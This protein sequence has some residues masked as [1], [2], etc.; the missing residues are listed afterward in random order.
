[1]SKDVFLSNFNCI[2]KCTL[3]S[4]LRDFQFRLLHNAVITNTRLRQWGIVEDENCT[5]CRRSPESILHLLIECHYSTQLGNSLFDYIEEIAGI[6]IKPT[7]AEFFLGILDGDL[8]HF[9][10]NI[11]IIGKQYIYASR[12]LNKKPCFQVLIQKI[13]LEMKLQYLIA[14]QNEK[15]DL[16]K[17][18]WSL[19]DQITFM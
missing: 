5:F 10:N 15:L 6:S 13:R 18:K 14:I 4:K 9:Y 17:R 12:C 3:N 16:W 8:S 11:M 1:M 19:L 2:Y 7:K